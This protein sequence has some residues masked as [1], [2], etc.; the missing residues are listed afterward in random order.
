MTMFRLLLQHVVSALSGW[1]PEE[2]K[3]EKKVYLSDKL[4]RQFLPI[5]SYVPSPAG[6]D[7][8]LFRFKKIYISS[9][10]C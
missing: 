10:I 5:K 6:A 4:S 1:N 8:K 3:N 9:K 7:L 2:K